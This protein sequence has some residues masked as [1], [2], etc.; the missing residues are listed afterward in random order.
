[1]K[2]FVFRGVRGRLE[3]M[4]PL[5][6]YNPNDVVSQTAVPG[7]DAEWPAGFFHQTCGFLNEALSRVADLPPEP[8]NLLDSE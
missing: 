6:I 4:A 2:V 3:S 8:V 5:N 7:T 1:M